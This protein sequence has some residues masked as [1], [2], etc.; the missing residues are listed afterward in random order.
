MGGRQCQETFAVRIFKVYV[1]KVFQGVY[2]HRNIKALKIFHH[3][4]T[5]K[6]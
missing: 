4:L 5:K 2:M 6:K 3:I 1:N